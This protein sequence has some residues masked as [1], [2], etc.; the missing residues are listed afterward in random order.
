MPT[1]QLARCVAR[2]VPSTHFTCVACASLARSISV[3][4]L[5]CASVAAPGSVTNASM[6]VACAWAPTATTLRVATKRGSGLALTLT[7]SSGF[8]ELGLVRN[9]DDRAVGDVGGVQ[10]HDRL[11]V[12]AVELQ[13]PVRRRVGLIRKGAAER[14]HGEA[15][16]AARVR[17]RF[18]IEPI[19]ED[20]AHRFE[21]R[22]RTQHLIELLCRNGR[23]NDRRSAAA[24]P[25]SGCA[26]RCTSTPRCAG[27]ADPA[28]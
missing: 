14:H 12:D 13:Q 27:A 21:L 16:H 15:R 1:S 17:E 6:I 24:P 20:D 2:P 19:D 25:S 26:G 9:G 8:V 7:I 18:G 23:G 10:R 5:A 3:S 28:R 22:E 11:V 4:A